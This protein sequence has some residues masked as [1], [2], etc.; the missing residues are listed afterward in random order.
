MLL[1]MKT[2]A[3]RWLPQEGGGIFKFSNLLAHGS[4]GRKWRVSQSFERLKSGSRVINKMRA[5]LPGANGMADAWSAHV[6]S[7][8]PPN[9]I[10]FRAGHSQP[11]A[12]VT[13]SPAGD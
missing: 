5:R 13:R 7:F 9:R 1:I 8:G 2:M 6:S 3:S 11:G 4:L 10:G 12:L